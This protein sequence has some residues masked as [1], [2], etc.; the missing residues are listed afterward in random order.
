MPALQAQNSGVLR[1]EP[2]AV[3]KEVTRSTILD[4]DFE[5]VTSVVVTNRRYFARYN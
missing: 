4:E 2:A 5:D 3:E 1:V